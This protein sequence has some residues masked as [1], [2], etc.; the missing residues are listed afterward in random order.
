M[1][2]LIPQTMLEAIPNLYD[3]ENVKDP[4]CHIKLFTPDSNWTWHI[5]EM[6][7]DDKDTCFGYVIGHESELGY[8]NLSEIEKVR[9]GLGLAVELDTNFK[10]THLSEVKRGAK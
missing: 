6:S 4:I 2:K 7:K 10:A 8:F 3:T 9:G 1:S 5:I